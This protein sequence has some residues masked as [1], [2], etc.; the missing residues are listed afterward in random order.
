ME[1]NGKKY[2]FVGSYDEA[3]SHFH[4]HTDFSSCGT[5]SIPSMREQVNNLRVLNGE[6]TEVKLF[7]VSGYEIHSSPILILGRPDLY[8]I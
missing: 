6:D 1:Y 5:F 2:D 3:K 7:F 4:R 8:Y